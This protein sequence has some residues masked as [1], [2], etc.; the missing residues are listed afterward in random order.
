[1]A[2]KTALVDQTGRFTLT[3]KVNMR[4]FALALLLTG[5]GEEVL[6]VDQ[7]D[8]ELVETAVEEVQQTE[9]ETLQ[10]GTLPPGFNQRG[11]QYDS[12]ACGQ[13][14]PG[15]QSEVAVNPTR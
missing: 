10:K 11:C 9:T 15:S 1:M 3:E 5:C 8:L 4:I 13:P 12:P 2:G 6:V 14:T 7:P